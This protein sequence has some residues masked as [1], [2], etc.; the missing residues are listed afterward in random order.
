M[1]FL[2]VGLIVV[3]GVFFV[4]LFVS[5]VRRGSILGIEE[6]SFLMPGEGP[7]QANFDDSG[8]SNGEGTT[9]VFLAK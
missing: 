7:L 5:F 3:M 2:K 8:Y 6:A 1:N 4:M 9:F